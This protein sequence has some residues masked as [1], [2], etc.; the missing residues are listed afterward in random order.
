MRFVRPV[1]GFRVVRFGRPRTIDVPTGDSK[2]WDD[3]ALAEWA[4]PVAGLNLR[5]KHISA[6]EYYAL[7]VEN[8][9]TYPVYAPGREPEGYW[10]K[11]Q[12]LGPQPLIDTRELQTEA[13]WINA[14][15]RVFDEVDFLH[16]RTLDPKY[17][18][19]VR[20]APQGACWRTEQSSAC[21]GC[22]PNRVLHSRFRTAVFATRCSCRDG[23]GIWPAPFRTI[24][25][26][27]V[28]GQTRPASRPAGTP[29]NGERHPGGRPTVLYGW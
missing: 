10:K 8:L 28:Q 21:V 15:K 25:P 20:K 9:R 18:D 2:V 19:E 7:K 5:P 12:E 17:V 4:T 23:R 6:G 13:D 14:G 26:R 16:L 22:P 11:L 27:P 24:V 3:A 1:F 29:A